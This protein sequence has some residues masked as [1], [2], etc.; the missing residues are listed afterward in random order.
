M[1][2]IIIPLAVVLVISLFSSYYTYTM[3]DEENTRTH[4]I[5]EE[6][7]QLKTQMADTEQEISQ[8]ETK[9]EEIEPVIEQEVAQQTQIQEQIDALQEQ[10]AGVQKDI[11]QYEAI[12]V[13]DPRIL[14]TV[15]DTLV[16]EKVEE[17]TRLCRTKE[18]KQQAVFEYVRKEIEYVTEGNPKK[19]S[20]PRSFLAYKFDFWQYPA[21]TIQWRKGDCEDRSILLCTM[22]RMVGVSPSNVRVVVG[23]LHYNGGRGGH[24]WIEFKIGTE[25]YALE[26]TCPTCNYI[27]RSTYYDIFTPDILGWFN[28][29]EMHIE[30]SSDTGVSPGVIYLI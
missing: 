1:N 5:T 19:W 28:D 9:K 3:K 14:I 7:Q 22:M 21:E 26:S 11:E 27:P 13:T 25:W 30:E 17:I 10:I 2:K 12:D 24:A 6:I 8:I 20:Y 29:V 4:T 18:E 15:H 23:I 16:K